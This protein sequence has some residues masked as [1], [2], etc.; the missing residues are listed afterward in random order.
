MH[1]R[2]GSLGTRHAE[3]DAVRGLGLDLERLDVEG[4]VLAE[5]VVG[6]LAEVL[7]GERLALVLSGKE[8]YETGERG[9]RGE[10]EKGGDETHAT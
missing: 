2:T 5:E 9:K 7:G 1:K 10:M 4:V 3:L 6:G 8:K